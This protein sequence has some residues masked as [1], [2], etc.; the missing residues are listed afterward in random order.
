LYTSC[1]LGLRPSAL[2][3]D[4]FAHLSTSNYFSHTYSEKKTNILIKFF[5]FFLISNV[6]FIKS[7][8][9]RNPK[10]YIYKKTPMKYTKD[11]YA[12]I[13][14]LLV[15]HYSNEPLSTHVA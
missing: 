12:K 4:I 9:G 7:A 2:F 13:L 3:Y 15:S 5:F 8:E 1:V 6:N 10:N 11:T 14:L